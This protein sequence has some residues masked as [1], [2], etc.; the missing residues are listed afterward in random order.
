MFEYQGQHLLCL[1]CH[2]K[3][4]QTL[5]AQQRELA[6]AMNFALSE[7]EAVTGMYGVMPRYEIEQPV[8]RA[9]PTTF[10]NFKIDGSVIGAIN[11]G[12]A[13]K[14]DVSL[15]NIN[16]PENAELHDALAS[17]TQSVMNSKEVTNETKNA[18]LD[19]LEA[20]TSE[21][22]KPKEQRN[23]TLLTAILPRIPTLVSTATSL[24]A[25]WNKIQPHLAHLFG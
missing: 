17:F 12:R 16:T 7:M 13:Q 14:M 4:Q 25:L 11:T 3:Y 2:S 21:A 22:A 23:Q 24:V 8:I 19:L 6:R 18:V 10:N 15:S 20:I 9:G 5:M 1:D